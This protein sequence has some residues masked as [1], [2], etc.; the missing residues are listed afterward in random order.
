[1]IGIRGT[2][3][4][5]AWSLVGHP[6]EGPAVFTNPPQDAFAPD[7]EFD[8][9]AFAHNGRGQII[10]G[11]WT[12]GPHGEHIWNT[13]LGAFRHGIDA[14]A[15]HLGE[16][17][18]AR[19]IPVSSIEVI[20]QALKHFNDTH[21][22]K[23]KH[24]ANMFD[25]NE[26]RK[27][28]GNSLPVGDST[29]NTTNR[30]LRTHSGNK[31]TML[32]NKNH[33]Q[34]PMGRYIESYYVP[35]NQSLMR[36]LKSM[37]IPESE[38]KQALPFTKYPYIY[39]HL[40]APQNYLRSYAKQHPSEVDASMMGHAPEG[41]YGD[42]T[43]VHTW[44]V[45]HHLPD[46]FFYPNLKEN[47]QKK[48]K[49]P[50]K[51]YAAA[52]S[53]I[54]KALQEGLEHIPNIDITLNR[55]TMANPDMIQRPLHEVL[56]TPDLKN[57]LV[58]DMAHVPAMMF[59]FG[60]S[61][62]GDFQKLYNYMMTKYGADEDSLSLDEQAKYLS[63]GQKGGQ[64]MHESAKRLF[65]LARASGEGSQE[66][67]SRFGEHKITAD[68]IKAAN[69]YHSDALMLQVGRFR[70]VLEA[71]AD[72]QASSQG[73][74][75]RR[76][77]GDIPTEARVAPSIHNYPQM[78]E[79]GEYTSN[80]LDD[81][82]NDYIYDMHHFAPTAGFDPSYEKP[83]VAP[84]GISPSADARPIVGSASSAGQMT[85]PSPSGVTPQFQDVRQQIAGYTPSQFREMMQ[86]AGRGLQR[87]QPTLSP[88]EMR[89]QAAL[90]DPR[91][92][93]LSEYYKSN[94]I[95]NNVMAV[96]KRRV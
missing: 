90:A 15:F 16:F 64:G 66:G 39:A 46:I 4:L 56:Q 18:R 77:L 19:G 71:L 25:S 14:V 59:L 68:E 42:T 85:P 37:G 82:M 69:M 27:I 87:P 26:W 86:A 36:E 22:N 44:E 5:K 2:P 67:R 40:T 75:V 70:K 65:A 8:I 48:G 57:A 9:P 24:E 28:R 23:E 35:F 72:H 55:G 53:M 91:Q 34:T 76:G 63:A 94:D 29:E 74:E 30:P 45:L 13:E 95:M 17:L 61:G 58:K 3:L 92:R 38:I 96:L 7:G 79:E 31:I 32:T 6:P 21:T 52:H 33:D 20:N 1:M 89:T 54:D 93:M 50:T 43:K 83:I 51:L 73:H 62:Q 88:I 47:L 81:H 78:G 12:K 41:Y 49:Q 60:R 84:D 80:V 10:P 11:Q